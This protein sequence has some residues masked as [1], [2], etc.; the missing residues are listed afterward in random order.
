MRLFSYIRKVFDSVA[1]RRVRG[2][3]HTIVMV[4]AKIS[5][6]TR[7]VCVCVCTGLECTTLARFNVVH[8]LMDVLCACFYLQKMQYTK[9][10]HYNIHC[11]HF[12]LAWCLWAKQTHKPLLVMAVLRAQLNPHAHR[13]AQAKENAHHQ[14]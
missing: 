11:I 12:R 9:N 4:Y 8:N 6:R 5:Q 3:I 10:T 14:R 2:K 1:A 13:V 7:V